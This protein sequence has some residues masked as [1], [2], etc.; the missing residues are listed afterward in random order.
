MQNLLY[1]DCDICIVIYSITDNESYQRVPSLIEAVRAVRTKKG[2]NPIPFLIF[3][4]KA[5]LEDKRKV[6][7]EL[8]QDLEKSL[9]IRVIEGS[10]K[11]RDQIHEA[12]RVLLRL[13]F[14]TEDVQ[15]GTQNSKKLKNCI[16]M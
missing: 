12:A 2:S 7:I 9:H 15:D 8:A 5:D 10:C 16:I 11:E 1:A 14:R 3:G 4:N 13:K 6:N